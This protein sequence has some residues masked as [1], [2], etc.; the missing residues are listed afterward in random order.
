MEASDQDDQ[1]AILTFDGGIPGFGD[2]RGF[3]L[4]DLTDDG[5]FQELV[6]IE[7]R[8]LSLVVAS[9]WLFF[10]GY[11]PD[12]PEHDREVLG[13]ED[14]AEAALFCAVVVEDEGL[15]MNL[16]APFVANART[17]RARQV[18]LTEGDLPLRAPLPTAD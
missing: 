15:A 12:L 14:P 9:P 6:C 5:T 7:D 17:H 8:G 3:A 16:R 18:V 11:A 4:A 13:I 10:P 2:H 1:P